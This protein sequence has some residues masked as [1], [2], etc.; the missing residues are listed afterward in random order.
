M[1]INITGLTEEQV[2]MLEVMWSLDS[3]EEYFTWYE[4]LSHQDQ[5]IAETL[6]RLI[7]IESIDEAFTDAK[8]Y[9]EANRLL[10]KYRLQ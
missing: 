7:I 9:P 5:Q 2:E 1:S 4:S 10:K 6:Q 8:S 3:T